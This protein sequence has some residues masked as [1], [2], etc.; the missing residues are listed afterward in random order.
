MSRRQLA[1]RVRV[2][3]VAACLTA[4]AACANDSPTQPSPQNPPSLTAPVLDS[5]SDDPQLT[6]Q[7]GRVL[8]AQSKGYS[9][10]YSPTPH[11]A[12]VGAP[13]PRG[14]A[15]GASLPGMVVRDVWLAAT[16]R[17]AGLGSALAER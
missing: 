8:F 14:G 5:P 9:G 6:M 13:I 10:S 16:A 4:A 17:P 11:F 15:D 12:Y 3:A 1:G 7:N 2:C